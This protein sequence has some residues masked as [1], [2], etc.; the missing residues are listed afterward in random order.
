LL[1]KRRPEKILFVVEVPEE[2]VFAYIGKSGN[3]AR[4]GSVISLARKQLA[5]RQ[6][7]FLCRC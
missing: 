3:L 2:R 1:A 4:T 5:G 6:C 7:N